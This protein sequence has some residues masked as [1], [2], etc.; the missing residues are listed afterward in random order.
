VALLI[1]E[2]FYLAAPIEKTKV[3]DQEYGQQSAE[4]V[5]SVT[6]LIFTKRFS[7]EG[8]TEN[9]NL[10]GVFYSSTPDYYMQVGPYSFLE[11]I[12]FF[13]PGSSYSSADINKSWTISEV[14]NAVAS[15]TRIAC[16]L[17]NFRG[18]YGPAIGNTIASSIEVII[19]TSKFT[20]L[21]TRYKRADGETQWAMVPGLDQMT[22]KSKDFRLP[23]KNFERSCQQ[24]MKTF[25]MDLLNQQANIPYK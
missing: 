6:G 11:S 21:L 20:S 14:E 13:Y 9:N 10:W 25:T 1:H 18:F 12:D 24:L 19:R 2:A 16:S 22:K 23:V 17:D 7:A 15:A 5:R 3:L 8:F 4:R